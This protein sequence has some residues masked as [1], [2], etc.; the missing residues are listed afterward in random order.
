MGAKGKDKG[1]QSEMNPETTA[2]MMEKKLGD[3]RS[4]L[5]PALGNNWSGEGA[6]WEGA[7]GRLGTSVAQWNEV[8]AQKRKEVWRIEEGKFRK[9]MGKLSGAQKAW[10]KKQRVEAAKVAA[11]SGLTTTPPGQRIEPRSTPRMTLTKEVERM[12]APA[13]K[14]SRTM[15]SGA[16]RSQQQQQH[17]ST[18]N[19]RTAAVIDYEA[20]MKQEAQLS[21]F[22]KGSNSYKVEIWK[23]RAECGRMAAEATKRAKEEKKRGEGDAYRH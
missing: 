12:E 14:A 22:K 18:G 9:K 16:P 3:R 15:F 11:P 19:G 7:A 20:M 13:K 8:R 2:R 10:I 5:D 6:S 21:R 1:G 4:G 17:P 23:I